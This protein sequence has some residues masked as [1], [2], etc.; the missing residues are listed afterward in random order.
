L[1]R[2]SKIALVVRREDI[3]NA[4][5]LME[6]CEILFGDQAREKYDEYFLERSDPGG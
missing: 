3:R 2:R 5:G 1:R 4:D 6:A